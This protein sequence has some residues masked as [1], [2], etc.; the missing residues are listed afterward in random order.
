MPKSLKN[1]FALFIIFSLF[2]VFPG[3]T[4]ESPNGRWNG[5][6]AVMG[7]DLKIM[8]N[9]NG[10]TATIDIPQ[11]GAQALP[12]K[13][14]KFKAPDISFELE[15]TAGTAYFNGVLQGKSI[16]GDF[17][18]AGIL[19]KFNLEKGDAAKA[20]EATPAEILPYKKEEVAFKNGDINFTGTLTLPE[21]NGPFPGVIMITGSGAQNRDEEIFDFKIFRLIADHLTR[22][23][24][25]V[26]RYDD[27]GIGGSGGNTITATTA[28]FATDVEAAIKFLRLRKDIGKIGL[29]GHSEGGIIAPIVASRNNNVSFIVLLA[30]TA[31]KGEDILTA[32]NELIAKANGISDAEIALNEKLQKKMFEAMK[33]DKGWDAVETELRKVIKES[34]MKLPAE[35]RKQISDINTYT[36]SMVKNQM[37]AA[38]SPWLRY[39]VSF[40]PVPV[41]EK[42]KVPVLALFGEK[43]LQVPAKQNAGPMENALKKAGN[44]DYTIK[45]FPNANHLFQEAKTGSPNEY[46]GLK[47]QFVPEMLD[48]ISVWILNRAG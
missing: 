13:N 6:I 3:I 45:I 1:M 11:Q 30:G 28:D 44:K 47:K 17:K 29:L 31:V 12:L 39:F 24:I 33:S 25:A 27:R 8:V 9:I 43:D 14:F 42:V 2:M 32:Q 41:L 46:A 26:L 34:I 18:Q 10:S 19:G 38:K 7:I 5:S 23:G 22:S 20:A 48:T 35:E 16:K 37:A 4:Q 36:E 40:D 21:S 15:G